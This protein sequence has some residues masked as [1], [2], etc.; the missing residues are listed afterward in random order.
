[1]TTAHPLDAG[2]FEVGVAITF[3]PSLQEPEIIG[4]PA[5]EVGVRYGV[6]GGVDFGLR[7]SSMLML[8]LDAKVALVDEAD[9]AVAI[10][11]TAGLSFAPLVSDKLVK[12]DL[13]VQ[14][15]VPVLV[16]YRFDAEHTLTLSP[17]YTALIVP[18]EGAPRHYL[19]GGVAGHFEVDPS[20]TLAPFAAAIFALNDRRSLLRNIANVGVTSRFH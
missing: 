16:D 17:R 20:V 7:A 12:G 10:Q 18:G 3:Y 13:M 8:A 4:L 11:P 15:D 9:H 5:L 19:G 1:M 2:H 14:I 6:G